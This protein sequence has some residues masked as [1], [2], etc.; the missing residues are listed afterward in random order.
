M[1]VRLN[2]KVLGP[3]HLGLTLNAA[4]NSAVKFRLKNDLEEFKN[5]FVLTDSFHA[6][7]H[8]NAEVQM[9]SFKRMFKG[10]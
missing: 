9:K 5:F 3:K 4:D 2:K 8:K 6:I 7:K 1:V 10:N